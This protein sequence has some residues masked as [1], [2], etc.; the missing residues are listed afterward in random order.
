MAR[1]G[2]GI[3]GIE[4]S[5]LDSL[6]LSNAQVTLSSYRMATGH[7]INAP[8]DD[9]SAF[10]IL[11]GVQSQLN[12]VTA[13]LANVTAAGS[14]ISQT[15]TALDG[16]ETQLGII[17]IE[18]LK[19]T[20]ED[21]PLT[22]D[23]RAAAQAKIDA[24]ID[25]I[26]AL[27]GTNINGKTLLAGSADYIY[28][29]RD[30]SQVAN[31]AVHSKV[32]SSATISGHVDTLATQAEIKY[33]GTSHQITDDAVFTLTG[34]RG[35]ATVT[36]E[37]FEDLHDV[38]DRINKKSYQTGVTA[39]VSEADDKL[40]F[41]SVDYGSSASVNVD[42]IGGT[43]A[44]DSGGQYTGTNA[45]AVINGKTISSTSNNVSGSSFTVNDNSMSFQI[46]FQPDFTGTFDTITVEGNALSF[47]MS[48]SLN[49]KSTVAIPA[50]Y[51]ADLGGISGTLN[52]LYSGGS[53]SGLDAN[54]SQA[55]M[56][57]DE[58]LGKLARV[59][60]SVDGFY[61]AAITS[62][63]VLLSEMQTQ[64]GDYIDSIDKTND[65]EETLRRDYYLA[66]ADNA[67]SGLTIVN[68]Q[69]RSIVNML[70]D[71]AGLNQT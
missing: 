35:S 30:S 27:A 28:S 7:K 43:F 21:N 5:L 61:N 19:D 41:T 2:S 4:R 6:A 40:I 52:E 14:M 67:V 3:T 22:P 16:I 56:V 54:T 42:V 69:R 65:E 60:G 53:L 18:L 29:G 24:A 38:A 17:R 32:S 23:E 36:V 49:Q 68:Q 50:M 71:I 48:E 33:S 45:S 57:V 63:S 46:E 12:T 59:Q 25:Q 15:H 44:I 31:V 8:S 58:T 64:L 66:L 1:I 20:D 26:N 55:I 34:R 13:T 62:S 51:P 11:S 39:S 10:M 9:P 37:Q 47:A 70:Q